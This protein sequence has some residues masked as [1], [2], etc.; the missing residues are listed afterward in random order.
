MFWL[1]T[2]KLLISLIENWPA[3]VL[4]IALAL[5]LFVFHQM[6]TL[7]TRPLSVPLTIETSSTMIPASSYPQ[8]VRVSIRGDD[9]SVK[10]IA[11]SDIGAYV[12]FT[13]YEHEGWYRAPIQIQKKGSALGVE[14]LEIT[15]NP[16]EISIQ[17]DRRISKTLPLTAVIRGRVADGFDMV[18]HAIT[19]TELVV[20]GPLASLE[21]VTEILTD[22]IDLDGRTGDFRVQVSIVNP[23]SFFTIRGSGMVEFSSV[24]RPAVP[25]RNIEGIHIA[26]VGLDSRF[27]AD[28]EGRTGSVRLE[29]RQTQLDAFQ[30]SGN[31]FTVDCSDLTE[32]GT[33]TLPVRVNLPQ[34][35][36]LV[37]REPE[38]LDI[39]LTLKDEEMPLLE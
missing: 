2:R 1:N 6:N 33:Y 37:R 14:P 5:V 31:F 20:T 32:P 18:S 19:P 25:V 21:T 13:R 4:S 27:D 12:D 26:L 36:S 7:T 8:N 17:L 34:G 22:P 3:K 24:I 9:E 35:F 29:G 28:I 38:E 39:T 23:N 30:P 15:V 16:L 10:S 11:E